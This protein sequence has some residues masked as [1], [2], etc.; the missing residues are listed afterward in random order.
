MMAMGRTLRGA[1]W[2]HKATS[3]T[4]PCARPARV[5]LST[6]HL[7]TGTL[8]ER[9][10]FG[11][12]DL[13]LYLVGVAGLAACLTL[14][15]LGMRAVMDVGGFCA[16]GGPYVIETHCPEGVPLVMIGG[17]F[18]LFGFGGLT[19]WKGSMIGSSYGTLVLLAWPAL[20]ISLGWNFLEYAIW[21][22]GGE[23]IVLGWLIPGVIFVLMGGLPLL[24]FLRIGRPGRAGKA[25]E[26]VVGGRATRDSRPVTIR[27]NAEVD[28]MSPG[29]QE[30]D[31]V[32]GLE[33][34][35]ALRQ[36]GVLSAD[37][38]EQAKRALLNAIDS[39]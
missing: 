34:L 39:A 36:S 28:P 21:P 11:I 32:S 18:G 27:H 24:A 3:S 25:F 17:V 6:I 15:F 13:A 7:M 5:A 26:W 19:A 8:G 14:V 2:C 10:R 30:S 16:E 33:R 29:G 4:R 20:F 23:G 12:A 1:Q 37:E 22:P 9:S 31:L 38:F 35:A